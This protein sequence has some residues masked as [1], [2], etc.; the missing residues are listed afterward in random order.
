MRLRYI[1]IDND[2]YQY[3]VAKDLN[4][5]KCTYSVWETEQS[6]IPLKRLVD[7]CNL[8]DV[9][10]DYALGLT[11]SP[12]YPDMRCNIDYELYAYRIKKTRQLNNYTQASIAKLLNTDNGVISRYEKGKTLIL[13]TFLIEYAKIFKV[14]T[15][16]LLGRIDE[17]IMLNI[18]EDKKQPIRN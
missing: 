18:K 12:K 14:S 13:T 6:T 3:N 4:V 10:V 7:F 11:D 8:F 1:R 5:A 15:D 17:K 9:S 16:Y 2:K